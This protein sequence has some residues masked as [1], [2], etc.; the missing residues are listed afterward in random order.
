MDEAERG[1]QEGQETAEILTLPVASATDINATAA[2]AAASSVSDPSLRCE[3]CGKT[4]QNMK[5]K[6]AH[7][8]NLHHGVSNI[9]DHEVA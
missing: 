6:T 3:L 9:I 1:D 2:G 5:T 8:K 7:L 4:F